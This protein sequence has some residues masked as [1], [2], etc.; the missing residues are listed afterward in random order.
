MRQLGGFRLV[1]KELLDPFR[2]V[3][4]TKFRAHPSWHRPELRLTRREVPDSRQHLVCL[5]T[6]GKAPQRVLEG[7]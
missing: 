1:R 4:V 7:S 6:S 3:S 2:A 5:I